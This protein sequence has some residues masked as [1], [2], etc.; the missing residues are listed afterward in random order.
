[1]YGKV[2]YG[3]N[4]PKIW[5]KLLGNS[6]LA[7]ST[8][9]AE[10]GELLS[11]FRNYARQMSS[12]LNLPELL[13]SILVHFGELVP[14]STGAILIYDKDL[15]SYVV[16]ESRGGDPMSL[17]FP[18]NHTFLNYLAQ[19]Q[20][21]L[22][23]TQI[24]KDDKLLD[25]RE[26]AIAFLTQI[27]AEVLLPLSSEKSL[28]GFVALGPSLESS[29]DAAKLELLE[30]LVAMAGVSIE[31]ALLYEAMQK[32]NRKL[33]EVAELK[34][35]FVQT[36]SHELATPVHG[37]MGLTQV[38][39]ES[40]DVTRLSD[41]QRRYLIMLRSAGEELNDLVDQVLE[42]TRYQSQLTCLEVKRIDFSSLLSQVEQEIRPLL[43]E[44]GVTFDR[45][46]EEKLF[47]YGDFGQISQVVRALLENAVKF[48]S[49]KAKGRIGISTRKLGE[50]LEVC[51]ADNGI[52][53]KES[54]HEI[55][56]E[57][58]RQADSQLTRE[59]GGAGLGLALA[60]KI[61]ELHGG[62]IW[63]NSKPG[64]GS[65]FFFTLPLRPGRVQSQE[66]NDEPFKL[67]MSS[68]G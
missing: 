16:R 5:K 53:I 11:V 36:V 12:I 26:S 3:Q 66:L 18:E 20:D 14:T 7:L 59:F 38:L 2:T 45:D 43:E 39:L 9:R 22:T 63:V 24:I 61:I 27:H 19:T 23:K 65:A 31:N 54:D 34:T 37:I 62:R 50:V 15:K 17:R 10:S 25:V 52:G 68:C 49:S 21:L 56:F 47:V 33:S 57:E 1:M 30:T 60:R 32:Q 29:Y 67:S 4:R 64:A 8:K 46:Y 35:Q 58:F 41:D 28:L 40:E 51:V 42:L 13:K 55:I 48:M 6:N 44:K